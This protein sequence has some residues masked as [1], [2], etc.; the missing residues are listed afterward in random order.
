M[1][2]NQPVTVTDYHERVK[3]YNGRIVSLYTIEGLARKP[4]DTCTAGEI[5][6]FSGIEN[7][8]IGETLC[9]QDCVVGAALC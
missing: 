6:C 5:V 4:V 7:I 3:P 9:A 8:T 2:V 1:K